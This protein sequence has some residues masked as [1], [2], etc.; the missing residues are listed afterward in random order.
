[1]GLSCYVLPQRRGG[2]R[3]G[4]F[5]VCREIPTNKKNSA[6]TGQ[7][8][9]EG[10]V[11]FWPIVVSS[12]RRRLSEPEADWPKKENLCVLRASVVTNIAILQRTHVTNLTKGVSFMNNAEAKRRG[13]M[14]LN[15]LLITL[16]EI[17]HV[18]VV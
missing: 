15:K 17:D 4:S 7:F 8:D 1:M 13:Q 5:F 16:Q 18:S 2:R 11:W 10:L 14:L 3:Q 9:A 12:P 6:P